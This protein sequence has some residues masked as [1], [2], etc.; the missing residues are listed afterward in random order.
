MIRQVNEQ[1]NYSHVGKQTK[2][3]APFTQL[4]HKIDQV[5]GLA[6]TRPNQTPRPLQ[7]RVARGSSSL[8]PSDK[9]SSSILDRILKK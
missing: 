1:N 3:R 8:G 2:D 4:V 9:I 6:L 5:K 7:G